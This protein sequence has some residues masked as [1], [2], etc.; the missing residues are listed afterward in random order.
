[1]VCILVIRCD[2]M[3]KYLHTLYETNCLEWVHDF[4]IL[5]PFVWVD[6]PRIYD[7]FGR[8]WVF[9]V[10]YRFDKTCVDMF[11]NYLLH[12]TPILVKIYSLPYI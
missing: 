10:G 5:G 3:W 4:G 11:G 6:R 7:A 12:S 8:Y 1:M 9:A 2:R